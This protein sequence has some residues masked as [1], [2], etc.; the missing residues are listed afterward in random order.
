MA[1]WT[2]G[3]TTNISA[4]AQRYGGVTPGN[5]VSLNSIRSAVQNRLTTRAGQTVGT[6]GPLSAGDFQGI[7]FKKIGRY[8]VNETSTSNPTFT[9]TNVSFGEVPVNS[10]A[11]HIVVIAWTNVAAANAQGYFTGCTIGGIPATFRANGSSAYSST[12][13]QLQVA[14]PTTAGNNTQNNYRYSAIWSAAVSSGTSGTVTITR[15]NADSS[16]PNA[17]YMWVYAVYDITVAGGYGLVWAGTDTNIGWLSG[18]SVSA[19]SMRGLS[20]TI[21]TFDNRPPGAMVGVFTSEF[22]ETQGGRIW[23]PTNGSSTFINNHTAGV[24]D[25]G[26]QASSTVDFSWGSAIRPFTSGAT[27][28]NAIAFNAADTIRRFGTFCAVEFE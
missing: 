2:N 22:G 16:F 4:L 5:T 18:A 27:G 15:S 24:E 17:C 14:D 8:D 10:Q 11:R 19:T 9:F 6:T 12:N 28:N 20:G 25:D 23:A 3:S 1:V 7:P 13:A 26:G 21:T